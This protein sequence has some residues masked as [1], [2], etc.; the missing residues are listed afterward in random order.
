MIAI[1]SI[2]AFAEE[3][4]PPAMSWLSDIAPPRPG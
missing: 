3:G 2:Q 4:A 1:E